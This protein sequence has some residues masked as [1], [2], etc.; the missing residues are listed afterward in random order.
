M[1]DTYEY[2]DKSIGDNQSIVVATSPKVFCPTS[3]TNLLL[4]AV[5]KYVDPNSMSALDL[6][7]GCGIV[8]VVMGK[9]VLP[10]ASMHASDISEEAVKLSRKNAETHQLDL[11]CRCGS[12]FEPWENMKFDLIVDDV[13]GISEPVAR[14][15][16]WY[17][18]HIHSNT[19]EDGARWIITVLNQAPNYLSERGQLFFPVLS[20]SN[21]PA[22]MSAANSNFSDVD[23][24][25]EQWYPIGRELIENWE[26]ME[27]L[28]ERGMISLRKKGSRWLWS[29]KIYRARN[30]SQ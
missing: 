22:I 25:A 23:L 1:Q 8:G 17:P 3:T 27:D 13:A 7:C 10:Q 19:D 24:V 6:G 16:P 21:E 26:T 5:R 4:G 12:L 14:I 15:S 30:N 18:P 28:M 9:M 29:T 20:L 2:R 11:D